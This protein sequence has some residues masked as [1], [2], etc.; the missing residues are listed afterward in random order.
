MKWTSPIDV[1][2][3]YRGVLRPLLMNDG[4]D[5][6]KLKKQAQIAYIRTAITSYI[7]NKL[8]KLDV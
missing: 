7:M 8:Y 6:I 1:S 3:E 5:H 4:I 2:E